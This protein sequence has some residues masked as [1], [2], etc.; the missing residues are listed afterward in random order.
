MRMIKK[1][2]LFQIHINTLRKLIITLRKIIY[3]SYIINNFICIINI[4]PLNNIT[5]K[6]IIIL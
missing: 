6:L 5:N 2:N 1:N 4:L 3:I